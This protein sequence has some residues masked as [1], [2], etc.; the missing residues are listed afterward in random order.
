MLLYN[1]LSVLRWSTI[2]HQVHVLCMHMIVWPS[3]LCVAAP[4][5]GLCPLA[6]K[7]APAA[8][9]C[10]IVNCVALMIAALKQELVLCPF[11]PALEHVPAAIPRA[12][13][14]S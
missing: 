9:P 6:L 11:R 5:T 1:L 12:M 14:A 2:R 3:C 10:H 13:H 7:H 4:V 8:H